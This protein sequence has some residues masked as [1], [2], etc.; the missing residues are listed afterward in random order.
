M[1][2]LIRLFVVVTLVFGILA[3]CSGAITP[4]SPPAQPTVPCEG[5]R[6]AF[7]WHPATNAGPPVKIAVAL[8]LRKPDELQQFLK[9]V[10]DPDSARYHHFLSRQQF[11]ATYAPSQADLQEVANQLGRSGMN[12]RIANL[13]VFATGSEQCVGGYFQAPIREVHYKTSIGTVTEPLATEPLHLTSLLQSLSASVIGL[14]G[15]PPAEP[16]SIRGPALYPGAD[17]MN[18]YGKYGP[19]FTFD[20]KQAYRFPSFQDVNGTGVTI[21]IVMAGAVSRADINYYAKAQGLPPFRFT[22]VNIDGGAGFNPQGGSSESTLDIEQAGGIAPKANIILYNIPTLVNIDIYDAYDAAYSKKVRVVN[23][24]FGGCEKTYATQ[25]YLKS[26]D[27]LFAAGSAVG[28]TLVAASGDEAAF[29]CPQDVFDKV[30]VELPA[31]DPYMLAVGGTNLTTSYHQGSFD[32]TYVS[33]SAFDEPRGKGSYWGSGG[34]YSTIFSRPSWQDGFVSGKS[35]G[36]PDMALHMGGL[37]FSSGGSYCGGI[38][39]NANDSSV[40]VRLAGQWIPVIGTSAASPDIVGLIALRIEKQRSAL[41]DIHPWLYREAQR[42]G[43][44][45][46]GIQD[47]TAITRP[48]AY[49]MQF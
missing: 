30:S 28:V 43:A 38:R 20:L 6:P 29:G 46:R 25:S 24:S 21:A 16:L 18:H 47:S 8:P 48:A 37:G 13:A 36:V 27:E 45:R 9:Q 41:G 35:R 33:E 2:A 34:G 23:S 10:S 14:E 19:Y 42:G 39:C 22:T 26:A 32:S 44:F 15:L 31:S 11:P 49:G 12:T 7:R 4:I 5:Q 3:G 40:W 1:T 17:P